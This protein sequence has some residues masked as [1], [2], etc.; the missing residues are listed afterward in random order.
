M[1]K[2]V[3][4][5]G[6]INVRALVILAL[7]VVLLG[8]GGA[9]GYKVRKRIMANRALAAGKA[10][11]EKQ[12]WTEACKR[13]R[14][15]LH[16]YPDDEEILATYAEAN[17]S[18]QPLEPANVGAAIGAYRQLLRHNAGDDELCQRLARLYARVGSFDDVVYIC[19][20]RLRADPNDPDAALSLGEALF[21]Q[22]KPEEAANV[23]ERLVA[24]R[25]DQVKGYVLLSE[26][27]RRRS[28]VP[29]TEAAAEWLDRCVEANPQSAE[30]RARRARLRRLTMKDEAAAR[31][32][33]EAA[34]ALQPTDPAVRLLLAEEWMLWGELDRAE[35]MLKQTERVDRSELDRL[36]IDPDAF[37]LRRFMTAAKLAM[38]RGDGQGGV[39]LADQALEVLTD[40]L[41]LAFLTSAVDLYLAGG[42][43]DAAREVADEFRESVQK[44]RKSNPLLAEQVDLVA[45]AVSNAEGRPHATINLLEPLLA[46]NPQRPQIWK[47]LGNAYER[48]GQDR[49]ALEAWEE[50][51]V[52]VP[53]DSEA[54]LQ[55]A[56]GYMS[57]DPAKALRYAAKA[58]RLKPDNLD[59]KLLEI[60][61]Q[62]NAEGTGLIR[63]EK[64]DELQKEL[65]ALRRSNPA[66]A[67]AHILSARIAVEEGRFEDATTDIEAAISVS[68]DKVTPTIQLAGYYRSRNLLDPAMDACRRAIA[69]GPELAAPRILL[70]QLQSEANQQDEARSTLEAAI[71]ALTGDEQLGAQVACAR[72]LLAQGAREDGITRLRQL[73]ADHTENALLLVEL[74]NLPEIQADTKELQRLVDRLKYIE[75]D[76][77]LMWR[78]QQAKVWLQRDDWRERKREA[79]DL[80]GYCLAADPA[81]PQPAL[82]VGRLY[83]RLG[84]SDKAEET[85]R[86]LLNASPT[87]VAVA[88]R[89]LTL[90]EQQGRFADAEFLLSSAKGDALAFRRH[91]INVAIGRKEFD[92]AIAELESAVASDPKD[93]DL[94]VLLA[95]VLY[96]AKRDVDRALGLLDEA[97]AISPARLA[98]T[99]LKTRILRSAGRSDEAL[100]LLNRDVDLHKDFL[101]YML[102][103]RHFAAVGDFD[104]AEEDYKHLTTFDEDAADGYRL[105][106]QFYVERDRAKD[107]IAALEAGLKVHPEN[108]S[109]GVELVRM[110]LASTAEQDR[111]RA[112]SL[113]DGLLA[114]NPEDANVLSLRAASLLSKDND[115]ARQEARG[116]LE[117]IVESDARAVNACLELINLERA[118]GDLDKAG[119]LV[120]RALGANPGD[121]LLL[122]AKA[123]LELSRDRPAIARELAHRVLDIDSRSAGGLILL[124]RVDMR[125]N[126]LKA[127]RAHSEQAMELDPHNEDGQVTYAAVLDRMGQGD[128]AIRHLER[129]LQT[130]AGSQTVKTRL[131]L[132]DFNRRAGDFAAAKARLDEAAAIAPGNEQVL[133]ARLAL[134]SAQGNGDELAAVL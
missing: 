18:V 98:I 60:E 112:Q 31:E 62:I 2:A 59:A 117:R 39:A 32:D 76:R 20:Q 14:E 107:G 85:Y 94:R 80:L 43:V 106:A 86:H 11:L 3:R 23:I 42:R 9:V 7:I 108:S 78:L 116:I 19:H 82:I 24:N 49:R 119:Y 99:S 63:P 89:L 124:A 69:F 5:P 115:E 28:P 122:L 12:D 10:A 100:E 90:L 36:N 73:A 30:A 16:R 134:L 44:L 128:Q 83:E 45:A 72:L 125:F 77:G 33:L 54:A 38:L 27:A 91:R 56:E 66:S 64:A 103:A 8:G 21:R 26:L 96:G 6:R 118:D 48:T 51:L 102:R 35:A 123:D 52:R 17:L 22:G 121:T 105:L 130:G 65:V 58:H 88:D 61:A 109:L 111:E 104:H 126:D 114:R 13:L 29:D 47:L 97:Q 133:L 67:R 93:A 92:L 120:T 4:Q 110:L 34:E 53:S 75:G 95:F 74:L 79:T 84:E 132:A 87:D 70:A 40:S 37:T 15:Y 57:R 127:A 25:P 41:R 129:F 101:A 55:L 46:R 81:W 131:M 1:V 71:A 113:L 68:S 50:Y